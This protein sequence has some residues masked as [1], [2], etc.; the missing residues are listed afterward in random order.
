MPRKPSIVEQSAFSSRAIATNQTVAVGATGQFAFSRQIEGVPGAVSTVQVITRL[1]IANATGGA[2]P[3]PLSD[4]LRCVNITIEREGGELYL[5]NVN[6]LQLLPFLTLEGGA[7][8]LLNAFTVATAAGDLRQSVNLGDAVNIP[9]AGINITVGAIIPIV[10]AR[11]KAPGEWACSTQY[12]AGPNISVQCITPVAPGL[13]AN[14]TITQVDNVA[15]YAN[16]DESLTGLV[17]G[18]HH[19]LFNSFQTQQDLTLDA[20]AYRYIFLT[21]PTPFDGGPTLAADL[22]GRRLPAAPYQNWS[23]QK[24]YLLNFQGTSDP[25]TN[26]L[27]WNGCAGG[28]YVPLVAPGLDVG[29]GRIQVQPARYELQAAPANPVNVVMQV[30][31]RHS[32][33]NPGVPAPLNNEAIRSGAMMKLSSRK[34]RQMYDYAGRSAE[35]AEPGYIV[36]NNFAPSKR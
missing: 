9:A 33:G 32:P 1:N 26:S 28:Y 8:G 24:L 7:L 5:D 3:V 16:V 4:L 17:D 2:L 34:L 10:Q 22:G 25:F 20:R 11:A 13:P 18:V 6:Y 23:A 21:F 14:I 12:D 29:V 15:V 35:V 30:L 31:D 19:R 27:F 36:S